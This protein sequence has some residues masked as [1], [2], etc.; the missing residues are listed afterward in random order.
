MNGYPIDYCLR[1][2]ESHYGPDNSLVSK[3]GEGC[4]KP[5]ADKFCQLQGYPE[6]EYNTAMYVRMWGVS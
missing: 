6:S 2:V 4:G 5:A 3:R 1:Y